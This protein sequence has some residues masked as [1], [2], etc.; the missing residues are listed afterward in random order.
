MAPEHWTVGE[1]IDFLRNSEE[2]PGPVLSYGS[3]L[4]RDLHPVASVTLGKISARAATC[5][6]RDYRLD[7]FHRSP[8]RNRGRVWLCLQ[9][10]S[11]DSA[12][13]CR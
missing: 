4:I 8:S 6:A 13:V 11:P 12:P 2:M 5:F 10:V 7:F 1:L 9:P 3:A